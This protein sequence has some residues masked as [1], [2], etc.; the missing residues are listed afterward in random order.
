[1]ANQ[2]IGQLT[3]QTGSLVDP[4]VDRFVLWRDSATGADRTRAMLPGEVPAA[5]GLVIG[6]NVQAWDAELT[7]IAGLTSA[8]NKLPYFTG[9]GTAALTDLTAAGRAILDDVDATAQR[10][11]LGLTI[12]TNVQAFNA[13]LSALAG[14]T[15]AADTLGY[16]TGSGTAGTT[17]LTSF[18]RSLI[19]DADATA[20]RTTL[21][22]AGSGA[23]TSSGLTQTTSRLLGRT[24]AATGAIEEITASTGL[25]FASGL[26]SIKSSDFIT[27]STSSTSASTA[28]ALP[29]DDTLP[30]SG[31]GAEYMTL[32]FTPKS[33]SSNL[34]IFFL[35]W[36]ANGTA[37]QV[38]TTALFKDS[39]TDTFAAMPCISTGANQILPCVLFSAPTASGSTSA[40][41]YRVRF[42]PNSGTSFMIKNNSGN[43]YSTARYAVLGVIELL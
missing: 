24:T 17:T 8:A 2:N 16:F 41:T 25:A 13:N 31:E 10:A 34:V 39:D 43:Y 4:L 35:G 22:A 19:D 7:A 38:T 32:S 15:S 26:L 11:T 33:A 14:L 1:M 40:R 5:I 27:F 18:G 9:S 3:L 20:G 12:G 23:V 37:N 6:T 30:Q 29:F 28:T 42:G 21:S 36:V